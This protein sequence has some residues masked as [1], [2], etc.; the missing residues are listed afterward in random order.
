MLMDES[1]KCSLSINQTFPE[2]LLLPECGGDTTGPLTLVSVE[3]L[4]HAS[5]GFLC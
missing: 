4:S 2:T 1:T 3:I 5:Q